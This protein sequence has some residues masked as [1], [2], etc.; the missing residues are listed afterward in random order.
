VDARD[1]SSDQDKLA[2][3]LPVLE[4]LVQASRRHGVDDG[5]LSGILSKVQA[6]VA[7]GDGDKEFAMGYELLR[8]GQSSASATDV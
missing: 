4:A 6:S 8:H 2:I 1:Y 5:L 7:L 3:H